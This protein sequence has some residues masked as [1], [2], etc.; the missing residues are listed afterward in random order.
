M[1]KNSGE[2]GIELL[3]DYEQNMELSVKAARQA[4][5]EVLVLCR[6]IRRHPSRELI[7]LFEGSKRGKNTLKTFLFEGSK[8]GTLNGE[9]E[10]HPENTQKTP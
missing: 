3:C 6:I 4:S 5:V 7:C 1:P 10:K 9:R 2:N 8:R